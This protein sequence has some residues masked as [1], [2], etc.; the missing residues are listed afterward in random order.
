[1]LFIAVGSLVTFNVTAKTG[2]SDYSQGFSKQFENPS[3]QTVSVQAP[4]SGSQ[5][6]KIKLKISVRYIGVLFLDINYSA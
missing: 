1:M 3:G 2:I 6:R 4:S 5:D